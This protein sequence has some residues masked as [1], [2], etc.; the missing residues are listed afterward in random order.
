MRRETTTTHTH[1]LIT[2]MAKKCS[3]GI[4]RKGK[5]PSKKSAKRSKRS[6][7]SK[8]KSKRRSK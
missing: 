5:C 2:Q 4:R 8:S 1:H 7:R 6:K 3:Y